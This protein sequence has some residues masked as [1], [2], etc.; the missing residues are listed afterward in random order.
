MRSVARNLEVYNENAAEEDRLPYILIIIDELADVMNY[1]PSEVEDKI[2]RL[3]Q[4]ARATG[5]HLILATQ[6]PSVDVITGLIK[7]NIPSRI[8]FAVA[9]NTDSRVI[10][11]NPGAEKLVGSGDMLFIPPDGA[12][13]VRI[14][15][16][17]V[18]DEE[19]TELVNFLR[20]Q[21]QADYKKEV[22]KQP[23]ALS[24]S[25]VLIDG[26]EQDELFEEAKQL[27][28]AADKGSASLL[29]RKLHV[30]YARAARILDQLHAAGIVGPAKGSKA[31]EVFG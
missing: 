12:K 10:L 23:V 1:S 15:G 4:M 6:R 9:S 18:T 13:P 5:V 14:Q 11:D 17:F 30:G 21:R 27:V 28:I 2:S 22:T 19:V 16:P 31:R 29:Q 3:A 25:T 26:E 8:S 7:A 24:G 20:Q